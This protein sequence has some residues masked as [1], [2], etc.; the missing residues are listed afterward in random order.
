MERV[1]SLEDINILLDRME[2]INQ[3]QASVK[4]NAANAKVAE[5]ERVAVAEKE[6]S[7]RAAAVAKA[8][9]HASNAEVARLTKE[10][11]ALKADKEKAQKLITQL[12]RTRRLQDC[13]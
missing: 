7:A 8:Q 9:L 12:Q 6:S 2:A 13:R 11:T 4:L 3:N 1:P 5:M 10:K